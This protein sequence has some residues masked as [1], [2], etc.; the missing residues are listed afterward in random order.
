MA[1]GII[2]P[3]CKAVDNYSSAQGGPGKGEDSWTRRKKCKICGAVFQTI[4]IP[5]GLI[6]AG[7]PQ[8]AEAPVATV[9]PAGT[10]PDAP[11]LNVFQ[12]PAQ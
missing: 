1:V 2:C 8:T 12:Q 9:A 6:T 5:V 4:E 11:A 10:V 7:T 3:G